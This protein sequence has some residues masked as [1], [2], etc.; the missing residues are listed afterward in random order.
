MSLLALSAMATLV[1]VLIIALLVMRFA[2]KLMWK[3]TMIA[4]VLV[5]IGAAGGAAYWW[6]QGGGFPLAT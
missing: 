4:I 5:V 2:M 6:L 3:L 1:G